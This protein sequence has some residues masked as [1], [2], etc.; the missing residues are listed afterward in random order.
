[1]LRIRK[2]ASVFGTTFGLDKVLPPF[3]YPMES[4]KGDP[5]AESSSSKASESTKDIESDKSDPLQVVIAESSKPLPPP[6][7]SQRV[8][9]GPR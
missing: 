3:S 5:V 7:N 8:K 6:N 4:D 9:P 1:M 2:S